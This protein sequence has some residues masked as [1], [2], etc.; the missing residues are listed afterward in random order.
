M[1]TASGMTFVLTPA[2]HWLGEKVVCVADHRYFAR[3]VGSAAMA[4]RVIASY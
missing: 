3:L 4:S 2:R 1:S